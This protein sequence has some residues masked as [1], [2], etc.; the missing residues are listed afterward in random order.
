MLHERRW[1]GIGDLG[2]YV[3]VT[4]PALIPLVLGR[5]NLP[6]PMAYNFFIQV[7]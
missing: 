5:A 4:D 2:S 3:T 1:A 7:T 6:K